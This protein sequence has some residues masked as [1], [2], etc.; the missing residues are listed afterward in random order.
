MAVEAVFELGE[1]ARHVPVIAALIL[2]R[3]VLTHLK[4]DTCAA[5]GPDPVLMAWWSHS[6]SVTPAKHCSPSLTTVQSGLRLRLAKPAMDALQ[7][8]VTR[9]SCR[10]TGLPSTAA[11]NGVLPSAGSVRNLGRYAASWIAE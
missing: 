11:T 8:L 3:A 9:P 5:A 6:A 10:R 4:V 2:P 1:I 7:K